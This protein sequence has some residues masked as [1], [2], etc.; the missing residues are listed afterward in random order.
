MT[1]A[2]SLP[3]FPRKKEVEDASQVAA[4]KES[5][6]PNLHRAN[7]LTRDLVHRLERLGYT[8]TL[9]QKAA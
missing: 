9:D 6:T 5:R 3:N 4:P 7:T 2:R 8:V 1:A